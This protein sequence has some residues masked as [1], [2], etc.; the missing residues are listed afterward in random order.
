M[1][2]RG[3]SLAICHEFEAASTQCASFKDK[4]IVLLGSFWVELFSA[5]ASRCAGGVLWVFTAHQAA[6]RML[7]Q[8]QDDGDIVCFGRF[9]PLH[10]WQWKAG[11]R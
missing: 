7:R 9:L 6:D 10:S 1:D 4:D 11:S 5:F 8:W 3:L 2:P